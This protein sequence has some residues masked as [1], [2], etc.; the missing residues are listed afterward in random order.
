MSAPEIAQHVARL[1]RRDGCEEVTV[2]RGRREDGTDVLG[3]TA[4]GRR[5]VARCVTRGGTRAS[6][7]DIEG[8]E[9]RR[10]LGTSEAEHEAEVSMLVA[11]VPFTRE[12]LLVCARHGVTAVHRGLLEAWNDGAKLHALE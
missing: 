8:A 3:Y 2:T 11:T 9:V 12:A 4:G 7:P 1:C 6:A 5:L 10:F